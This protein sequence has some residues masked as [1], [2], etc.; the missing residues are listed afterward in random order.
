MLTSSI[1]CAHL[2]VRSLVAHLD[3]FKNILLANDF[4][5]VCVGETW[6]CSNITNDDLGIVGYSFVRR[7]RVGRG[8]GVGIFVKS[9]FAFKVVPSG[10]D[11]EQLWIELKLPGTNI[12]ICSTY[13]PLTFNYKL[14]L[15]AFE[16]ELS[17]VIPLV[18][19]IICFGDFNIDLLDINNSDSIFVINFFEGL[20]LKQLVDEPTR[21][22]N[23]S[24]TLLDYILVNSV[25]MAS[26]I[27]VESVDFS[28][29]EL[30]SCSLKLKVSKPNPRL[31]TSR[32]FKGLN[33]SQFDCDLRSIPW[34]NIYDINNVD[35]K[36]DFICGN[37][38]AL[39]DLNAPYKTYRTTKPYAPWF[40][41][42]L[43]ALKKDRDKALSKIKKCRTE[44]H[45]NHY[46]LLRNLFT[47]T[48]RK[49]KK[50]FYDNKLKD[51]KGKEL[52]RNLKYLNVKTSIDCTVNLPDHLS[53]VNLI[54]SH[55]VNSIPKL[56]TNKD[57]TSYYEN[58]RFGEADFS[59]HNVSEIEILK[60]IADIKSNATGLD[61]INI[62]TLNLC[63]PFLLPYITHM[64]NYSISN[65]V[66][67]MQWKR[68]RVIPLPKNQNPSSF[69]NLRPISI[70]PTL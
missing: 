35:D 63:L 20:G 24:A 3:D 50:A 11:I 4:D 13:R 64:V 29:H 42:S 33:V 10:T 26:S 61:G 46:R 53:D 17:Q 37:I 18:N 8:G 25:D 65:S 60:V 41:E 59:F 28:D 55:F 31:V 9:H 19:G 39:L 47:V 44:R 16:T 22:T 1:K 68:A 12:A 45:W 70:L 51:K 14:F 21:I 48:V 2:N 69:N 36:V 6:L 15:D 34:R 49:E 32:D 54:N 23:K 5:I 38:V 62:L 43:R 56:K 40:T 27:R 57:Q 7:D 58:N 66:F 52:W 67:P 30:I